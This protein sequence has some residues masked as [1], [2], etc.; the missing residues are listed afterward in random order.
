MV[1]EEASS[2]SYVR[3]IYDADSLFVATLLQEAGML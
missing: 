3:H 1:K 2:S